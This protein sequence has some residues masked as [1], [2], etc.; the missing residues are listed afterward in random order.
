MASLLL[1]DDDRLILATLAA[2]L[3]HMGY[4][5]AVA[6]SVD[7]AQMLLDGG[8]CPDLA[9][10]DVHLPGRDG[11]S[12][13][14]HQIRPAIE[15]ALQRAGELDALRR[16]RAQLQEALDADREINVATGIAMVQY[17]MARRP[18]FELLRNAARAQQ[19]KLAV[20]AQEL[21]RACESLHR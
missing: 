9:I 14:L 17:R 20:V 15:T 5:V 1:V 16:T 4:Q 10:V 13:A 12:L 2:G 18:A 7:A 19:R 3:R 8:L 11:L 21:V 6:D